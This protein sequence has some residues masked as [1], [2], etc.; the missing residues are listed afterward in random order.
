M[1]RASGPSKGCR[2]CRRRRVK[3]DERQ[4]LCAR[5]ERGGFDCE[6]YGRAL[7]FVSE[8]SRAKRR[9]L[10]QEALRAKSIG[11]GEL[12]RRS[13][14]TG[15]EAD[16]TMAARPPSELTCAAFKDE[17]QISFTFAKLFAWDEKS[18][19]WLSWGYK[20]SGYSINSDALKALSGIYY[21]R[22]HH[23]TSVERYGCVHYTKT[24]RALREAIDSNRGMLLDVLLAGMSALCY[25]MIASP[26]YGGLL[27][28]A[29]GI[30]RL[31]ELRGP[32]QHRDAFELH[33][34]ST[35]RNSIC[36]KAMLDRK[37]CF[38]E[39]EEWKTI[40][41]SSHPEG[42]A[43]VEWVQD[44][45][46]D[47]PGL[48]E[49]YDTL[50]ASDM[51]P[52]AYRVGHEKLKANIYHHLELLSD[53]RAQWEHRYPQTCHER[54]PHFPQSPFTTVISFQDLEAAN[55]L[56]LYNALYIILSNLQLRLLG[57]EHDWRY[58]TGTRMKASNPVL[59]PLGASLHEAAVEI[60]RS[61]EYYFSPPYESVGAFFMT[62]PL[63]VAYNQLPVGD[64]G[65]RWLKGLMVTLAAKSGMRFST[66]VL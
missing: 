12:R 7:S 24:L 46:C 52:E 41:W 60:C 11:K 21:G 66:G 23:E 49:D 39:R 48:Y 32:E 34:L 30:G 26:S 10:K 14:A 58:H 22:A 59:N 55:G 8:N 43:M 50:S 57:R 45:M 44:I 13:T 19:A 28:H 53:W 33:L 5:C 31:I 36:I 65:G 62:F 3:C 16:L 9:S 18:I 38:L 4:P 1:V 35:M 56:M 42:R 20:S 64:P 25:E 17:I 47:V 2:T 6:G 40:P 61:V 37:R 63:K 15:S 54:A 27:L 51:S 29:G